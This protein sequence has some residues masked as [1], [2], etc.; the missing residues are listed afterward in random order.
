MRV[1]CGSRVDC[2]RTLAVVFNVGLLEIAVIAVLGLLIFGPDKLPKAVQ[3]LVAGIRSL[4]SAADDA[5]KSLQGAAG[6]DGE[7]AKQTMSDLADLHPKRWAAG[8]LAEKPSGQAEASKSAH[9]LPQSD[10][11]KEPP[12]PDLDPDLP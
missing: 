7:S 10:I 2:A 1:S 8:L 5:S 9:G 12:A 11:T 6:I 3:S 4:R